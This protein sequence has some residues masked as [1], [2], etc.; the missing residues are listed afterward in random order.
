MVLECPPEAYPP[1]GKLEGE[2]CHT[3]GCKLGVIIPG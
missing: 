3:G 2:R 1:V